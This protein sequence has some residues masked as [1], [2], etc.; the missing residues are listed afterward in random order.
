MLQWRAVLQKLVVG[1]KFADWL[2]PRVGQDPEEE[3][4]EKQFL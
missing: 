2:L 4:E 3:N 1:F